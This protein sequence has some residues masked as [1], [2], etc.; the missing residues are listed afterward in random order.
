MVGSNMTNAFPTFVI[1][2]NAQ[3]F[4]LIFVYQISRWVCFAMNGALV[5]HRKTRPSSCYWNSCM[6]MAWLYLRNK[7]RKGE[8]ISTKWGSQ[9]SELEKENAWFWC[10]LL[11]PLQLGTYQTMTLWILLCVPRAKGLGHGSL[12]KLDPAHQSR[13]CYFMIGS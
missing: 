12:Y 1:P 10:S 7:K 9:S 6:I 13:H 2:T 3:I 5:Q 8:F 4:T 11:F